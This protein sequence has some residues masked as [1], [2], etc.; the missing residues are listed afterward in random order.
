MAIRHNFSSSFE[1]S[2][3]NLSSVQYDWIELFVCLGRYRFTFFWAK[4]IFGM[5]LA[6]TR[7]QRVSPLPEWRT[8][9]TSRYEQEGA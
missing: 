5:Q 2:S 4:T 8:N 7:D 3:V 1:P 9:A 6:A